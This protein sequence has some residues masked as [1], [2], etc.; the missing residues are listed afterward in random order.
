LWCIG[1]T[2]E[3]AAAARPDTLSV[4]SAREKQ[5]NKTRSRRIRAA[6]YV[7]AA[8]FALSTALLAG[9]LTAGR[10][11]GPVTPG[12][13]PAGWERYV[14]KPG[15]TLKE[16]ARARGVSLRSVLRANEIESPDLSAGQEVYLPATASPKPGLLDAATLTAAGAFVTA[17]G[18]LVGV[19]LT[20]MRS[21]REMELADQRHRRE[22][23]LEREKLEV[24]RLRLEG[25]RQEEDD[26]AIRTALE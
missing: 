26:D 4:Q 9:I 14:L 22:V 7:L 11:T 3:A 5:V 19:V 20:Y 13:P 15:D 23:E 18:S 10:S 24:E 17:M 21:R 25:Q 1:P 2:R 16:L 12:V 6:T 8:I